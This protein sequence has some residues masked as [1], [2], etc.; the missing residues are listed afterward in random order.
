MLD[1]RNDKAGKELAWLH[2][3][4]HEW[5]KDHCDVN[6]LKHLQDVVLMKHVRNLHANRK[7]DPFLCIECLRVIAPS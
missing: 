4:G 6:L 1:R 2:V 3:N 7:K 5:E